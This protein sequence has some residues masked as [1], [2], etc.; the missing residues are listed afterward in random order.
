MAADEFGGGVDH[1][2]RPVFNGPDKVGRTEGVVDHQGQAVLMG[3]VRDGVD[4]RD[5]AVGI[6]QGLQID[7]LGVVLDGSLQLGQVVGIHEGGPDAVLGQSV[8]QQVVAA[9]ID[10]LLRHNM[11][12]R[13]GQCLDS[14]GD[15]RRAGG[16]GQ[17]RH[18]ALQGGKPLL[19]HI[20]GGVGE[21][22]V[23]VPGVRQPEPGGGVGGIAEHIG[24]CLINR[25]S[26]GIGSGVR[27]LLAHV[28]L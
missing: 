5:V 6:A 7:G 17:R 19:Q 2:V 14:I 4:V 8:G 16:G 23:N 3:D 9:A 24:G 13:L 12:P 10:G 18:A 15:C 27:P 28:E 1:D 22:P 25:H 20:L 21:P 26:P 11:I